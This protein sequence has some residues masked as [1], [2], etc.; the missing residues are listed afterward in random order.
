MTGDI[1]SWVQARLDQDTRLSDEAKLLILAALE[2]PDELADMAGRTVAPPPTAAPTGDEGEPIGAFIKQ[3]KVRGFRG[4]GAESQLDLDPRPSLT[5][6]SGRN[7]SGKSSFAEALEVALTGSTYRWRERAVEWEK[8]WRNIHDGTQSRIEVSL[9][10]EGSGP[11]KLFADWEAGAELDD[12]Q[13]AVQRHG[14]KKESGV[15]S[16][17]WEGPLSTYRPMLTYEELG[18]ILQAAPSVLYDALS[19]V[20]G[21]EQI[22][23]A[24]KLL[25]EH[26]NRLSA[27]EAALRK[28]R[29]ELRADLEA[30]SDER[31]ARASD[32]L[33]ARR[34]DLDELRGLAT[35]TTGEDE[36]TRH[37]NSLAAIELPTPE[38]CA[39]AAAELRDATA[40]L[41]Q[42]GDQVGA[43]V[44]QRSTLFTAAIA[45][46]EHAGDQPCPVCEG[47]TLDAA[48]VATMRAEYGRLQEE[49]S[50][51][52]AART[53][54]N[55]ATAAAV[56]LITSPSAALSAPVPEELQEQVTA[57]LSSWQAW[58]ALP[59]EPLALA[60]HLES[61]GPQ[62][63]QSLL[64]LQDAV[65][66]H[67]ETLD[68]VWSPMAARLGT[69]VHDYEQ[70]QAQQQEAESARNAHKW[71]RDNER[72]LKNER[73]EPIAEQ[74]RHIWAVLR[75]ESNVE[76]AGLTLEGAS[77]RRRVQITAEVDGEES[78]ALAVM[79]QGELHALALALFL[80]RATMPASPFR[81]VVLDDPVQAMDPAKVD[82]LV[83]VLLEIARSRQVVVFSHDDR[84][85]SAVRRARSDVPVK[86]LEVRR[87]ANS[88]VTTTVAYNPADRYLR[89]AFGIVKEDSLPEDTLRRVLP[90]LLRL[91]LEAQA[92]ETFFAQRLEAGASHVEVE[93]EWEANTKTRDR[94]ALTLRDPDR[95]EAWLDRASY[96]RWA[97]R[98]AH[99]VHNR[100][101]GDPTGACRDVEKAVTDI[102]ER[103]G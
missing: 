98:H 14:E 42:A 33:A 23:D 4:I 85:A 68:D 71:L 2:G 45:L 29:S 49:L 26:S 67:R 22:A 35:G 20:L 79:S 32:L 41:A 3:V 83:N 54:S 92:R 90:G 51:L 61:V 8:H 28:A 15:A 10:A 6:I 74:A 100:L 25:A 64:A 96:R 76:I 48:S 103:A 75:Q 66:A 43:T 62:V 87:E 94:I 9:V 58:A 50:G 34:I 77:T 24:V 78:G 93:A 86:V 16:L 59:R 13:R 17:G 80:P 99:A 39:Q 7:G 81:F 82:G 5:V 47:G 88:R 95:V 70:W 89:D 18:S 21:L 102:R 19:T 73:L 38:Q 55:A 44:E 1:T 57:C 27:P 72:A 60:E 40:A 31:A 69:F 52:N 91:A 56:G 37:L 46:H 36:L 65:T 101:E 11:T 12:I 84:F 30:M 53:R 97:L 63:R